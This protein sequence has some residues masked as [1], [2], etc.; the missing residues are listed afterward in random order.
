MSISMRTIRVANAPCSWGAFEFSDG[1][2]APTFRKVL[3]EMC[4]SGYVGTELGDWGF[5]PTDPQELREELGARKLDMLGAFV[6][7]DLSNRNSHE[8]GAETAVKTAKLLAG[9]S[10]GAGDG[11]GAPVIVLADDNG[12]DAIRTKNA[13]RI[14]P[15][16]SMTD[17]QWRTLTAGAETIAQRVLEESGL[18][19]VFHHHCAGFVETPEEID[20]FVSETDPKLIGLCFDTGHYTF[21]GGNA[22]H[23]FKRHRDRIWHLHFKDASP[24]VAERS[25]IEQWDYLE[26]VRNGIFCELGKG[27]VDFEGIVRELQ[28]DESRGGPRRS[29]DYNGWIVVEQDVLPGM[30]SP[31]ES[32]IRNRSYLRQI[33]L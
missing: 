3:D 4:Q 6:P 23:G 17:R 28:N 18:R 8:T 26:S 20:R 13:G 15:E 5:M 9:V 19:T 11:S 32:A 24:V 27:S 10:Q 21:G 22:L 29:S 1:V 16:H 33:G 12:K 2:E 7:V 30:G 14:R 25:R 31:L